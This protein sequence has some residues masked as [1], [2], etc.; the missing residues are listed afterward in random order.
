[1]FEFGDTE[2]D[3]VFDPNGV[4]DPEQVARRIHELR[5]YFEE[6][7]RHA[8]PPPYDDL[9]GDERSIAVVIAEVFLTWID[10]G[11]EKAVEQVHEV[12]LYLRGQPR[13]PP[14]Q[15][16]QSV[17]ETIL[18]EVRDWLVREGSLS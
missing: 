17:G 14:T 18:E 5:R 3:D 12:T 10:Q 9:S 6:K 1:M 2:P 4:P 13:M 11:I 15:E 8:V 7:A 16:E